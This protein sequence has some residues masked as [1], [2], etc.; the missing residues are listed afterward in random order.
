M[1]R[2]NADFRNRMKIYRPDELVL[3]CPRG[4]CLDAFKALRR[5]GYRYRL[6]ASKR[7]DSGPEP[8]WVHVLRAAA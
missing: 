1:P 2:V 5:G 8:V 3:L 7:L 6:V 4:N